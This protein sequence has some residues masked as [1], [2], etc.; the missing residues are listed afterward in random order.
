MSDQSREAAAHTFHVYQRV[1]LWL[2]PALGLAV[3]A[4][5][6]LDPA[7]PAVTRTAAV[8]VLMAVWWITDALPLSVT[9]LLPIILFPVLGVMSG[10]DV[11]SK[12]FD[13]TICLFM[14]GFLVAIAMERWNL[15][16]RVALRI[17][18]WFGLKPRMILLGFMSATA[19]LSMWISNTATAMMMIPIGIAVLA[20]LE[21]MTGREAVSK[22]G[23][24]LLIGIAYAASIGG[25][26][27]PVGTPPNLVFFG[28]FK[29]HF[30]EAPDITFFQWTCFA[31]PLAVVMLLSAWGILAGMFRVGNSIGEID[32]DIFRTQYREL[33]SMSWAERVVAV[34]FVLLALLWL[35]RSTIKIGSTTLHGW[36]ELLPEKFVTD[37]T[38]AIA[39]AL[40]L[41]LIPSRSPKGRRVLDSSAIEQVPWG[42]VLLFGGGFALAAGFEVSG[43]SLWVGE[44]LKVLGGLHPIWIVLGVCT[45]LTFLTELTSNTATA[46]VLLPVFA[47]NARALGINP[48]L[49][50]IP[51]TI[52]ASYAFM[53]PVGTP[54]NAIVFG[55]RRVD[56]LQ[57]A[58]AGFVLNLVGIVL[59]TVAIWTLGRYVFGFDPAVF[60][61]WAAK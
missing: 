50:M 36:G 2:G 18:L 23:A 46:T 29:K 19:F 12:Y 21:E 8:A 24:A 37:G 42:I 53:L 55:T 59:T 14:G 5:A 32:R 20:K 41:F 61:E 4:F 7:H 6:D 52:S 33:G 58:R 11:A 34:D 26:A 35:T 56:I 27:T 22:Y 60:P 15:H 31:T 13:D 30:P 25:I 49:L 17:L 39:L 1:G 10:K 9:S 57:M 48:M 45:I 16:R 43:L 51:A 47:A 44:Q 3:L 54:P 38:T 40:P 28:I